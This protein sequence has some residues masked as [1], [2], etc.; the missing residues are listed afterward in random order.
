M[1]FMLFL[2]PCFILPTSTRRFPARQHSQTDGQRAGQ[3]AKAIKSLGPSRGRT[4]K[5]KAP[6]KCAGEH[7]HSR[8]AQSAAK[9]K[10][11][12]R[13]GPSLPMPHVRNSSFVIP[14][15]ASAVGFNPAAAKIRGNVV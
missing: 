1:L 13:P 3:S 12:V 7:W 6:G 15:Y 10:A 5:H 11:N 2:W 4:V 14:P 8:D 9:A